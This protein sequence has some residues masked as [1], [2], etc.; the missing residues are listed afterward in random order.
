M[1]CSFLQIEHA[2]KQIQFGDGGLG[3]VNSKQ[4]FAEDMSCW[5]VG[6]FIGCG[7][8]NMVLANLFL[9][10]WSVL[11]RCCKFFI[12]PVAMLFIGEV[13]S[14]AKYRPGK[15]SWEDIAS[16]FFASSTLT[17]HLNHDFFL[18]DDYKPS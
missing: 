8:G 3:V 15:V 2:G 12:G 4:L 16:S 11:S 17:E 5:H 6:K 14:P 10:H 7:K 9:E 1:D 13:T 18:G